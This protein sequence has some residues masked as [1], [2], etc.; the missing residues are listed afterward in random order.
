MLPQ[1]K[2]IRAKKAKWPKADYIVGNPPFIG[3]LKMREALGD[4]YV[5]ALRKVWH[6]VPDSADFVMYWW[7]QASTL[8]AQGKSKQFGLITT[9]S[10]RQTFNRRVVQAALDQGVT[11]TFVV[12][13]HPWVDN[14]NGAAVRI[15]MT[16]GKKISP[17]SITSPAR[18]ELNESSL[19]RLLTVTDEKSGEYG[20]MLA[21][22]Q[23]QL[24]LI[25]ADLTTGAE[26]AT[27]KLLEANKELSNIGVIPHGS[28]FII[29][30]I[31]ARS[32]SD[33]LP[34]EV[35]YV[36]IRPY[37]NGRDLTETAR[38]VI[39]TDTF[40]F[41]ESELQKIA[42]AIW[43]WLHDRVKPERDQNPRRNRRENWWRYGE[44]HPR[45]RKAIL[46]LQRYIVTVITAKHRIFQFL[47]TSI[48]PDQTLV[49]IGTEDS[50]DL[51]VLSSQV[52]IN[53]ALAQGGTLEDRPRYNKSR[54]FETFPFPGDDTGLTPALRERIAS[55]AEQ[56]D[57]HHK[58]QQAAHPG[59]TL[60][61]MY[62]VLEALRT[63]RELTAKEKTIHT[64]GLVAVL[65][66]L[67]AE[68]DAA[69][70]S[71]YGWD[72][73]APA[74]MPMDMPTDAPAD[75]TQ[76]VG[77]AANDT[78]LQHLVTL[79]AQRCPRGRRPHPLA[80]SCVSRP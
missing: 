64:Q 19:G 71:A 26:V 10:L 32:L 23:E 12:P 34:N 52:H 9:N 7:S 38:N 68:L 11:L 27:A 29:S 36:L 51:G 46:G 18:V 39:A 1:W 61:G 6:D 2:Y 15:A 47:D 22:F 17:A 30:A 4:G 20:E 63:G 3:K 37:R 16:V 28:G 53:W 40:D 35:R 58:R 80:A 62:N 25:H 56:I 13:D 69:V 79:N 76:A 77:A 75:V 59:L 57:A 50:F 55:L 65:A 5:E 24:G 74:H 8:V 54:C 33:G 44:D 41:S 43:Q 78:L 72:D 45:V 73:L 49:V 31:E 60:T 70:L 21:E 14:T 67:H 42:P 48:L 66:S